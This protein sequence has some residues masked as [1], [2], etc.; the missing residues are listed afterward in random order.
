MHV[1]CSICIPLDMSTVA[2]LQRHLCLHQ[3]LGQERLVAEVA[4]DL[5]PMLETKPRSSVHLRL[6][7]RI[8]MAYVWNM[9]EHV[10]KTYGI[11][12]FTVFYGVSSAFNK[13]NGLGMI[14]IC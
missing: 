9:H 3:A 10:W 8:C 4:G 12:R 11:W 2:T 14:W 1:M 6:V 5:L 13:V 7:W